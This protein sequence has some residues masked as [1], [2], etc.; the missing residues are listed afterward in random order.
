MNKYDSERIAG[1]LS[2]QDYS[3]TDDLSEA[4]LI[5]LNTCTVREKADHKV[6]SKLGRLKK[7]KDNN[8]DLIIGVCGCIPQVQGEAFLGRSRVVDFVFGTQNIHQL[9]EMIGEARKG[10]RVAKITKEP[11]EAHGFSR[12]ALLRESGH[13]AWVSIMT[14]CDNFCTYCIVPYTRGR[15]RSR[16]SDE[17]IEEIRNLAE[18]GYVEVTLLG[19]NVN[20]YGRDL[21]HPVHF[22][23]LLERINEIDGIARIRFV[24]SHPKDLSDSLIETMRDS[25]KVCEYLHLPLQSGS[26]KIL[27]RMNRGYTRE[28]Y[29]EKVEKLKSAIPGI[30][31]STDIIVGFPGETEEDFRETEKAMLDVRFHSSFIFKY[32]PRP[33]TSAMSFQERVEEVVMNERFDR[34][35]ALQKEMTLNHNHALAGK[36][37]EVLVEG[38]S[39]NN[40][41]TLMG[42]TRTNK[43][44][45]IPGPENL[46]GNLLEVEITHA[47]LYSLYGTPGST[48][49]VKESNHDG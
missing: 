41:E 47:G 3:K 25:K 46:K 10:K 17:I 29:M 44:I 7:L 5:L 8:P 14:G 39:K 18:K 35:D 1:V 26:D 48:F 36:I 23:E 12:D 40:P 13:Q 30:A 16:E 42:R 2:K 11:P 27:K 19:Q 24:T 32:S 9:M 28:I 45:I 22:H 43:I 20:S 34:L 21:S 15:E 33:G 37:V 4:D 38:K 49:F 31:L 6:L